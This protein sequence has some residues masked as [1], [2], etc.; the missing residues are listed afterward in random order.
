MRTLGV[1][2]R[3][4]LLVVM[5]L[6]VAG[7]AMAADAILYE[8]SE[9]IAPPLRTAPL[10]GSASLSSPLCPVAVALGT[11]CTV[12]GSG[13]VN[14][15]D[16]I[17]TGSL[18]V[19]V[20]AQALGAGN[21]NSTDAPEI[22]VTAAEFRAPAIT[23]LAIPAGTPSGLRAKLEAFGIP[24][25]L[26]ITGTVG[27]DYDLNGSPDAVIGFTGTFRLPFALKKDGTGGANDDVERP[28]RGKPAFYLSDTGKLMPVRTEERAV[29][30]PTPRLEVTFTP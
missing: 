16:G 5:M 15:I 19:V 6:A 22:V 18:Y 26:G 25:L 12:T 1:P 24:V 10:L 8:T 20:E 3:S 2:L 28:R 7:P 4:F 27:I 30:Y 14:L 11:S 21:T 13:N 23:P 17:V 29:G 9:I